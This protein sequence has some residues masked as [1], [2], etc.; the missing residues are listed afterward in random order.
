MTAKKRGLGRGLDVLLGGAKLENETEKL[1]TLSI[2]QIRPNRFQPRKDIDPARLQELADSI[3]AQGIVQPVVVRPMGD[4]HYEIIA[5]ERRWRAAQLAGL[6]DLHVV[7]R[8]V[9]DQA[10]LAIALIEN[11]QREDLNPLEEAEALK[12]LLE[13]F[14]MTHQQ[15]ADAV[16]KSRATVSNLLRLNELHPEVKHLL[17]TG[18][19]EMGHARAILALEFQLQAEIARKVAGAKLSVRATELLVQKLRDGQKTRKPEIK[20]P[21]IRRLE[22]RIATRIGAPVLIKHG[23]KGAGQLVIHY[24]SLDQLEGVLDRLK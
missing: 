3:S 17:L 18:A 1:K 13:E 14:E 7:V 24:D 12:R 21:D 8:E 10:A 22:E 19:I 16:G 9:A 20:D 4:G 6:H 5:G 11:I 15:V 2:D 23:K